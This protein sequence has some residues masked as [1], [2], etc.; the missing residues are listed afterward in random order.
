M[1]GYPT[2]M[3]VGIEFSVRDFD[4]LSSE[5]RIDRPVEFSAY[6]LCLGVRETSDII[7]NASNDNN[8]QNQN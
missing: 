8:K 3:K 2:T 7:G 4:P 6:Y 1:R 5:K